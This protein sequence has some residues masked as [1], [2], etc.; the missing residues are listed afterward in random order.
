MQACS[1]LQEDPLIICRSEN[2][3]QVMVLEML[4]KEAFVFIKVKLMLSRAS[5]LFRKIRCFCA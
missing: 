2:W 1:G 3:L 5:D 4:V